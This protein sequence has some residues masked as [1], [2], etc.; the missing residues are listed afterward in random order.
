M[1]SIRNAEFTYG[2][3]FHLQPVSL[4]IEP[5]SFV[6]L[7]GPNGSGKT[8]L[9]SLINGLAKPTGGSIMLDG[10][11]VSGIPDRERARMMGMVSQRNSITFDYTVEDIIAMGRFP[12]QGTFSGETAG[13]REIV[14]SVIKRLDL[15]EYRKRRISTLSGGEYQRVLL[16]RVLVQQAD[17]LLL[18]EPGNHLDLKHQTML[19]NLLKE[20]V[21]QGKIVI[22]V[23]HDLNQAIH[24]GNCG[25]LL[26]NG[27]CVASGV[28]SEFLTRELIRDVFDVNLTEYRSD[29]GGLMY[30]LGGD[31][32]Q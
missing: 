31:C 4:D 3:G 8:T 24:Y 9:F 5:G 30:G 18:D 12:Y 15:I 11:E 25:L 6:V 20:E 32:R 26:D 2:Q 21:G 1:I 14:Q 23:L 28:P 10:R 17:I 19:L 27:R 13:D 22:A 7:A 29:D 16:G